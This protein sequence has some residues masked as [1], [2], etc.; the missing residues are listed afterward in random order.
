MQNGRQQHESWQ[1]LRDFGEFWQDQGVWQWLYVSIIIHECSITYRWKGK[2]RSVSANVHF[3][4]DGIVE[5][6]D[7]GWLNAEDHYTRFE[8]E[9]QKFTLSNENV[10]LIEGSGPKSSGDYLVKIVPNVK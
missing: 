6:Q 10:L 9:W 4:H 1:A 8:K 2:T 7:S 5:I 3:F